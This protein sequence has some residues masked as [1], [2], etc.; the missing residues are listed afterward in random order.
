MNELLLLE[1]IFFHKEPCRRFKKF[2]QERH[3]ELVREATDE[4]DI[5]AQLVYIADTLDE[6]LNEEIES[7]Y[8]DLMSLSEALINEQDGTQESS[9]VG[10][11]VSL[12]DGRSVLASV[13]PDVLNRVL[14]V[15]THDEL[16]KLVDTI[17]DAV[18]NPDQRPLCK[19]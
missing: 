11:A 18:E 19:R 8:D 4:T 5:Q 6:E 15:I 14:S 3:V 9:Q 7:Y 13:D 12:A 2:L 16:G 17:A 10:L 1:F